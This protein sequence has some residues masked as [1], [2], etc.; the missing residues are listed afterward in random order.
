[1]NGL[2]FGCFIRSGFGGKDTTVRTLKAR[3]KVRVH[4]LSF[5]RSVY[6]VVTV[7]KKKVDLALFSFC[8]KQDVFLET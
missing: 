6:Q 5:S 2:T 7:C 1:M 4:F 8:P 3:K